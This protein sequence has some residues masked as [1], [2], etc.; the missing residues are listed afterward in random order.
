LGEESGGYRDR[1]DARAV[2]RALSQ[3]GFE[4][5]AGENLGRQALVNEFDDLT[6]HLARRH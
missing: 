4:V 5:I 1:H 2:G 6:R 3:I